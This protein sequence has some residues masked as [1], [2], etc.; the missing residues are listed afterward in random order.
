MPRKYYSERWKCIT[1]NDQPVI[2]YVTDDLSERELVEF[3]RNAL[4]ADNW[5]YCE[6]LEAEAN[7]RGFT[8]KKRRDA[9]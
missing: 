7:G 4:D 2:I 5:E 3:F 6:A 8:L 1:I 9:Q